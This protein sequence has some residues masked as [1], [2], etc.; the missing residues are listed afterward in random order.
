M[1]LTY[2]AI[3]LGKSTTALDPTEGNSNN[4][5]YASLQYQTFGSAGS[6][7]YANKVQ[8]TAGN[9]TGGS[10]ANALETN[11]TVENATM[12]T[13]IGGTTQTLI[14]DGNAIYN[15]TL[16]Y[17]DGTTAA[18]T[19]VIAQ[20]TTGELFLLPEI[21]GSTDGDTAK[22]EAKPIVSIT[23]GLATTYNNVNLGADRTM[24]AYDDGFIDGTAGGDLID[25][26]YIEPVTSGSDRVD[27]GDA[28][29]SSSGGSVTAISSNDD[30][31]RAGDGNDTVLSGLGNDVVDAGT[32]ND[33]VLGG[34]GNDILSGSLGND[35]LA[36]EAG[37]DSLLG[38]EGDDSLIG[39]TEN[40][41]LLGEG[42][43]DTLDGGNGDDVLQGGAG[44]DRITGGAG[45]DVIDGGA[46]SD[47]IAIGASDGVDTVSGGETG[48]D[49]DFLTFSGA[50]VN[51]L[52]IGDEAGSYAIGTSSGSF[53]GIEGILGSAFADQ[54]DAS[55][56]GSSVTVKGNDGNDSII[57]GSGADLLEGNAG[58]DTVSGGVG[59]DTLTGGSGVDR[60][61]Y[62]ASDAAV[63]VNLV[64][65]AASGG[66]ATGD[67][68]HTD[69]E[70]AIGSA[71]GD[72][73]SAAGGQ[74]GTS[75]GGYLLDGQGGDDSLFGG[76][77][78]DTLLGGDGADRL[79]GGDGHDL[80]EGGSGDDTLSGGAGADSLQGGAGMDY[81]DYSGSDAGVSINLSTGT[82][83]GGH[84]EGDVLQGGID[85][86]TGSA[87]DDVL[88]GYDGHS[89]TPG[90]TWTNVF[91]GNGGNDLL[92]GLGGN[93]TLFGGA[94]QDTLL[95]GQ[96]DDA[97]HGGDGHDWLE[98]GA[99]NDSLDGGTGNDTLLA[100][101]GMDSLSGGDDADTLVLG[102]NATGG[103][104]VDGGNGGNDDDTLDLRAWGKAN[105]EIVFDP[106]S[107]ENGWVLL[108]DNAGNVTGSVQFTE[109]ENI[110]PC[111]TPGSLI[112]TDQGE[113]PVERLVA[114]DRVLT[115]DS[116]WQEVRWVGRRDLTA[117]NLAARPDFRPVLIRRGALGEGMPERDMLVSPQHRMLITGP[118]AEM[119]FGE[120]EVLVA[121]VHLLDLPGV[122]QMPV[123]PVSYIHLLCDR[124]EI[125]RAD[126]AWTETFQ[127][128]DMSLRGMDTPQRREVLTL[129]P[130]LAEGMPYPGARL[131][132]KRHEARVLLSA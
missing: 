16:T 63:M 75:T 112:L 85:G 35:T 24:T 23:T 58:N 100:D 86:I 12:T 71:Y 95:G 91:F 65:G 49:S 9:Y 50:G 99:G 121:A 97:L 6:P 53:S 19:G 114:G 113:R 29:T 88:I 14:Y 90:D 18:V 131:T 126:G 15:I 25:A 20:T 80:L 98:G 81:A 17:A 40:D 39:G 130:E 30:N 107:R 94:D 84:A 108:L 120:H 72:V 46:D 13:T 7:L 101:Q 103:T 111:F 57:G 11:N 132:L 68:I 125:I 21:T 38:G 28:A 102:L 59:A 105:T 1:P 3:Y 61:D 51:V 93:D 74:S 69:F 4:E 82:A 110:I 10:A 129:F 27:N 118:R 66:H 64:T 60:L 22:Y 89:T 122:V 128:G 47:Q 79:E 115:R 123:A 41:T 5:G 8:I 104:E 32:G 73:L 106:S 37:A 34:A 56:S 70:E 83:S 33:S 31:I 116:G 62:G 87:H 44:D 119:L 42:G 117:A 92:S 78:A 43:N 67:V 96:G 26:N 124:H 48:I 2:Q 109:I 45:A 55:A 77:Q 36:G 127:P 54:I 76:L 52:F